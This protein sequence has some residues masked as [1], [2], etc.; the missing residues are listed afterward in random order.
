MNINAISK[1]VGKALGFSCAVAVLAACQEQQTTTAET[2]ATPASQSASAK[3]L[4]SLYNFENGLNSDIELNNATSEII[5]DSSVVTEGEKALR[6]ALNGGGQ[7]YANIAFT[8]EKP[9]D[10]SQY[11]DFSLAFDIGNLGDYSVQLHLGVSDISGRSYTR[12]VNIAKGKASTYYSKM[13][14]HD[15]ESPKTDAGEN[16]ELNLSSGLRSNPATW[17]GDDTQFV[18]MWGTKN[19]NLKGIK[20]IT[21][22]VDHNLHNKEITIDNVRLIQ[23][24]PLNPKY[25]YKIVDKYG[26]NATVEFPGKIH[27]DAEMVAQIKEETAILN[28]GEK[29]ADR[30]AYSGWKKGPKLEAT[31]Y[32]RTEKVDGKWSIVDPDG[33]LYFATGI[34]IIRLSNSTTMTGYDFDQSK[35]VQ[36]SADDTTPE[37]STGL[38]R[39]SDE[40]VPTRKLV[41][42][43]RAN[44]F[45]WLPSYDDELGN[46]FGYRREAHSGPLEHGEVFS[47]YSANLER[48]YGETS[49]E[50]F[51]TTWSEVTVNRMLNWGFTSLGNWSDPEYYYE[52]NRI[53]YFANGWIIGKYKTV[54][55][56][57]DFWSPL[58]DPFDPLFEERAFATA[59]VVSEEVKG[60]PWCVGV[61]IDN[62]KSWGRL[63]TKEAHYGIVIDTLKNKD[64]A[65]SPTKQVFTNVMKEKYG[66]IAKLNTVWGTN[67]ESWDAFNAGIDSTINN[68]EQLKDYSTLLGTYAEEY[69]RIVDKALNHYMPNHMYMGVRLASW[70]MPPEVI[71]ASAKYADILSFNEYKEGLIES[72]W[73][74]LH[75]VD[76]PAIIGEFHMGA[77]DTG[78]FH[79]GL[80]HAENQTDRARMYK[81]YMHTVIDH[82]NFVGAHWFQYIDSPITGRA[83]DGENYNVGFVSV[84]D[85][86][87]QPMID[88]AKELHTELYERR[89]DKK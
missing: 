57:N 49:P 40:A 48:K 45:E 34:D 80:I 14:G 7:R 20:S 68:D 70:G 22:S 38:N 2:S 53:P 43:T 1:K 75:E 63:E 83:Y 4:V 52:N 17:E 6:V 64:G 19:L 37:D 86:P 9:W 58:P 74:F 59:K 55:S 36:R 88:A 85:V 72:K 35:I 89:F 29:I 71:E 60:N 44:M 3:T 61:F 25:L 12:S 27:N 18:W 81:D 67:I 76:K 8:P 56:G 51:L 50:S 47:F 46:H 39:V 28:G 15:L 13:H 23:N 66:E 31:G 10:W 87:Y 26:Q 77:T 5:K 30:S 32:F 82:P 69:F 16:V 42:E 24:P 73:S 54:S 11:E 41:S 65:S 79:P 21:L 33:Y 78:L 84:A 62:E